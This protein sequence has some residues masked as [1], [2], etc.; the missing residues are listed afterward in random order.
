MRNNRN[1]LFA[2]YLNDY[3]YNLVAEASQK[4]HLTK[5]EYVRNLIREDQKKVSK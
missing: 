2:V 3:E 1:K 5:A 4:Q